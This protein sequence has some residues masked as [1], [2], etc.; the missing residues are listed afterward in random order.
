MDCHYYTTEF[1]ERRR[2]Q[3]LQR[4]TRPLPE[5]WGA[6]L[7]RLEMSYGVV[8]APQVKQGTHSRLQCQAWRSSVPLQSALFSEAP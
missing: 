3:H 6:P 7:T 5:R 8:P 4:E 2:E 1:P